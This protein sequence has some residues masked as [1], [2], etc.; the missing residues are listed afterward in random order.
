MANIWS[1]D[2]HMLVS[3]EQQEL[4]WSAGGIRNGMT[5]LE[6]ILV[7]S[8]KTKHAVSYKLAISLFGICPKQL[9]NLYLHK[10]LQKD[11]IAVSFI[12]S[13]T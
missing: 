3:M 11:V 13:Q 2:N 4:P 12:I 9:K 5:I 8:Y 6:D 10:N 7:I 1:T